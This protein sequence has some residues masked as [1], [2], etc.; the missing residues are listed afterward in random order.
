MVPWFGG[1][2]SLDI[3]KI[4]STCLTRLLRYLQALAFCQ[5]YKVSNTRPSSHKVNSTEISLIAAHLKGKVEAHRQGKH[6]RV[7]GLEE[8][9]A[10]I[11]SE[12]SVVT[13]PHPVEVGSEPAQ[14]VAA[15]ADIEE[16]EEEEEED[17]ILTSS[18]KRRSSPQVASPKK[19]RKKI[20][21]KLASRDSAN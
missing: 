6:V 10:D 19:K 1:T 18:E 15:T 2:S 5:W 9:L 7:P 21:L 16:E 3:Q 17:P 8:F 20:V 4:S 12:A 13:S 11:A 14:E